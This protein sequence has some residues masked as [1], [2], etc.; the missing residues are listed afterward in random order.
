MGQWYNDNI[1]NLDE[2]V[3]KLIWPCWI[4]IQ[5][6]IELLSSMAWKRKLQS[7]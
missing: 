5:L 2:I 6:L 4:I 1:S 7:D 3:S